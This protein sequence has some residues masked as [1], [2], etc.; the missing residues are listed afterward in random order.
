M[1]DSE[2]MFELPDDREEAL[3]LAELGAEVLAA[4][5]VLVGKASSGTAASV[6]TV[7]RVLLDK[8]KEGYEGKLTVDQ[9]RAEM[10]RLTDSLE[11][12]DVEAD[13]ALKDK[14]EPN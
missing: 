5:F 13:Q 12:N 1:I 6:I 9:V 4:V 14:F 7:I 2:T 10:K 8:L 11:R 3:R